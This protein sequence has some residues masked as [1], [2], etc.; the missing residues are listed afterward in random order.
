MGLLFIVIL[1]NTNMCLIS[2]EIKQL[3]L[4]KVDIYFKSGKSDIKN[5]ST[6]AAS[7]SIAMSWENPQ[8]FNFVLIVSTLKTVGL[9]VAGKTMKF[10]S[11][12]HYNS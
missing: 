11:K 4:S 7:V 5:K 3:S 9:K 2:N 6:L 8:S 12:N 1:G 10:L